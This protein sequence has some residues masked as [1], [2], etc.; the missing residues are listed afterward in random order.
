MTSP[1]PTT[2][3]LTGRS[4]VV[5]GAASGIG[6][7]TAAFLAAAG[8]RLT[9]VDLDPERLQGVASGFESSSAPLVVGADIGDEGS[10][11]R[12][13]ASA[14]ET[15]GAVDGVVHAAGIMRDQRLD[16]RELPLASWSALLKV[17]LTGSF[18]V[19]REAARTLGEGGV[20]VLVG[21]GGG[22][23]GPSG[24]ISYGA[25]KGGVQGLALTLAEQLRPR[26]IRVHNFCPGI[27]DTPLVA[28]SLAAGVRNGGSAEDAARMRLSATDPTDV[29][30]AI[31]LL[32]SP[33][34][35]ALTGAVFSR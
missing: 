1:A 11:A 15:W 13:F 9:L 16:I 7:A 35:G 21:S 28:A 24:S 26:G 23:T 5:T 19:G 3:G 29:G 18:L 20:L 25:S 2:L 17:N 30:A 31:A 10:V 34:A 12:V 14:V 33:H 27:V 8:A 6:A 22:F 4:I 32:L